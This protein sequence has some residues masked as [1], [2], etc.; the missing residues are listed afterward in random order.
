MSHSVLRLFLVLNYFTQMVRK[1]YVTIGLMK[2]FFEKISKSKVFWISF[3]IVA[4]TVVY[5]VA[6]MGKSYMHMDEGY[7]YGSANYNK[8]EILDEETFYNRWHP[9]EYYKAYLV[10]DWYERWDFEPVYTNQRD[11][12]H[13]PL[14]HLFLRLMM[15]ATP[16]KFSFWTGIILN[17]IVFAINTVFL[18]LVVEKLLA[19]EKY[20]ETKAG[21][22]TLAACVTLA[23]VSTVIYIRMYAML[24]MWVTI[25]AYL[26]LKLME[27]K[28]VELKLL[29]GIGI[30]ALCGVLTQ[31]YY[32]FFLAP[33]FITVVIRYWEAKDW[34]KL[35]AYVIMLVAAAVVSLV[36]WP[37]SIKHLFFGYRGQGAISN[38]LNFGKLGE[39]L[40]LFAGLIT[41]YVF[42]Y[43]LPAILVAMFVLAVY[44]LGHGKTLKIDR[45]EAGNYKLLLWPTLFFFVIV[46]IA[47]PYIS[48]RYLE[49]ICCLLFVVAMWGLYQLVGMVCDEKRR[50]IVMAIVLAVTAV[51]PIPLGLEPDVEY[52]RWATATEFIEEKKDVPL[53]YIY[54]VGNNRFLDDILLFTEADWSY[55]MERDE[56][57]V[58]SFWEVTETRD[59]SKGLIVIA[60]YG[61]GNQEYLDMLKEA[62]G[63]EEQE[64]IFRLNAAD[65]YY[66]K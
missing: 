42:H 18:Y 53:L 14:F 15:E 2:K 48:L 57:T 12:V 49:A 4:Q 11:D 36:I 51:L 20:C 54:D 32:L 16:G 21:I 33:L 30:V 24:A 29:A 39:Q 55:I 61:Y 19:K 9:S 56:Y 8:L 26:H 34:K 41:L 44:G 10:S 47:S 66:L 58:K 38:L 37:W 7:S 13:P 6:G 63:L 45:Q 1:I 31:Y 50:N 3:V 5:V 27:A 17:I 22:L 35:R 65:L 60:N 43:T 64:Y 59:L 52:S 23:A 28:K 46:S 62:T 25:T 40:G